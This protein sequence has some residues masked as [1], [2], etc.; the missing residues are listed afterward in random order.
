MNAVLIINIV[1]SIVV[2]V[3]GILILAGVITPA[4]SS[5]IRYTFGIIF[6]AY[7]IY[8]FFNFL[9]KRK[10]IKIQENHEMI[11]KEK[12]KLINRK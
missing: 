12:D 6:M 10:L 2:F 1:T 9:S 5:S 11:E 4:V 3:I 7:G 8:R